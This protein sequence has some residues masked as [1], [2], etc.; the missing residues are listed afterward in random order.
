MRLRVKNERAR[1]LSVTLILL[2]FVVLGTI[3]R[4]SLWYGYGEESEKEGI[5]IETRIVSIE[6]KLSG[7]YEENI[8]TILFEI[9]GEIWNP[10]SNTINY[11]T[12]SVC[13]FK[14]EGMAM[15]D[16]TREAVE[17]SSQNT[18]CA[19]VITSMLLSPGITS[20]Q[21][22]AVAKVKGEF[23]NFPKGVYNFTLLGMSRSIDGVF[24]TT[25]IIFYDEKPVIIL[26]DLPEDWGYVRKSAT[27][28]S[29]FTTFDLWQV[30]PIILF[31][32][33]VFK[34]SLR[35]KRED[36]VTFSLVVRKK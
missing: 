20:V 15:L 22:S 24:H 9:G 1:C 25:R 16:N 35:E 19:Q 11:T 7:F 36:A 18:V 29:G 23:T 5:G 4:N 34:A 14:V 30:M 12:P 31:L 6:W 2:Y 26:P 27:Y 21:Q 3:S 33:V 13:V 17:I 32:V 10:T 28:V 8:T